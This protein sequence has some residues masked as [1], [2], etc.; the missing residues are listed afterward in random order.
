MS[1][2]TLLNQ[3]SIAGVYHNQGAYQEMSYQVVAGIGRFADRRRAHQHD[4]EGRRQPVFTATS[5]GD[6]L[7]RELPQRQQRR[8]AEGQRADRRRPACASIYDFNGGIGGP[9]V[10]N[11]LWFFHSTRALGRRQLHRQPVL[12]RWRSGLRSQQA[13]GV[14]DTADA[15]GE[16][17]NKLSVMYDALPKYR[18]YFGSET[19]RQTPDGSGNQDQFGFD[20]QV[21]WTSTLTQQ[22]ACR[23]RILQE[24]SRLQPEIPVDVARPSA[25]NPFGDISKSDTAIGIEDVVQ[26]RDDRVLQPVR[27]QSGRRVDVVRHR[28]A[29]HQGRTAAEVRLDQEHRHAERQHGAGL[30]Q[31]RA[32]AGPRLQ[33]AAPVARRISTATPASTSRIR[34]ASTG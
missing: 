30:Q 3:G 16:R 29:Q 8:R 33:H 14:H 1:V 25:A 21:K 32:A 22:A 18:D 34:G 27:R 19:G 24:L 10:K 26:R 2:M 7:E 9:I 23:S 17:K 11:R 31:R 5:L 20:E 4:S 12:R 13:A 28:F 15:A 6:V